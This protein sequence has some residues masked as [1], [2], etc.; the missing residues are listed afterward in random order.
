MIHKLRKV[1]KSYENDSDGISNEKEIDRRVINNSRKYQEEDSKE[2]KK[3]IINKEVVDLNNDNEY[4][5]GDVSSNIM[6]DNKD[7]FIE[8]TNITFGRFK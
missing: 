6:N 1:K 8:N 2:D 5:D 4:N 7:T 3:E